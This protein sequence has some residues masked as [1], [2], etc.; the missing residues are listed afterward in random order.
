MDSGLFRPLNVY[1]F[2]ITLVKI[3]EMCAAE[4]IYRIPG[5]HDN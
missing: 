1:I 2:T 4:L 5:K 3:F